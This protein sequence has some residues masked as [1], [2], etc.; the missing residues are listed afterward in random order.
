MGQQ[1]ESFGPDYITTVFL[2]ELSGTPVN[3]EG[4]C[5]EHG[6]DACIAAYLHFREATEPLSSRIETEQRERWEVRHGGAAS[7]G[8]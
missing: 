7:A 3:E 8:G 4:F 2:C 5:L 6:G 1:Q